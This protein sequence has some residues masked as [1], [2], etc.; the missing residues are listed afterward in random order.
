MAVASAGAYAT[1]GS[2]LTGFAFSGL[3]LLY[4]T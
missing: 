2:L 3:S 1:F 4:Y